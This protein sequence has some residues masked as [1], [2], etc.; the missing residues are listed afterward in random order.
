MCI[1]VSKICFPM[2]SNMSVNRFFPCCS[3]Y[4]DMAKQFGPGRAWGRKIP[5][6]S[7][8]LYNFHLKTRS[9]TSA[10]HET[11]RETV[12]FVV[13]PT[14]KGNTP[15]HAALHQHFQ[16]SLHAATP[17]IQ[18]G[19]PNMDAS[20]HCCWNEQAPPSSVSAHK[21]LDGAV[22]GSPSAKTMLHHACLVYAAAKSYRVLAN[23][24]MLDTYNLNTA[25]QTPPPRELSLPKCM[26]R[27][28]INGLTET[29]SKSPRERKMVR[30][31]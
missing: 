12:M 13:C 21:T 6:N 20:F 8:G 10:L 18:A 31:T 15:S 23:R 1:T 22:P 17:P 24:H 14:T 30:S 29:Q 27:R 16:A 9:L 4:E 28:R 26:M 5:V 2:F 25:P 19:R 7:H 3:R 11:G